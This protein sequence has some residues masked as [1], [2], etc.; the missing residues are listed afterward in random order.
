MC[1]EIPGQRLFLDYC[2]LNVEGIKVAMAFAAETLLPLL[3]QPGYGWDYLSKIDL[4]NSRQ[5]EGEA[6]FLAAVHNGNWGQGS[7]I[8][9]HFCREALRFYPEVAEMMK[10]FLDFHIRRAPSPLCKSFDEMYQLKT[11]AAMGLLFI[12]IAAFD[13]DFLNDRLVTEMTDVLE[14]ADIKVR[15]RIDDLIRKEH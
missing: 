3:D 8:I 4:P 7:E 2:H 10:L 6:Q 13:E 9:R 1:G 11:E 5:L 15:E 14:N 12:P